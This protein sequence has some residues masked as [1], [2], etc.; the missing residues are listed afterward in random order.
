[1]AGKKLSEEAVEVPAKE[2]DRILRMREVAE[3]LTMGEAAMYRFRAEGR[4]PRSFRVAG[5]VCYRESEV[6]RWL[7]EQERLED[8]RLRRMG[9]AG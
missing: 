5:R 2:E 6:K 1:V 4:G 7:A 3:M 9:V 8:E